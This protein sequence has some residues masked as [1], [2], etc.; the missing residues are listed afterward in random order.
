MSESAASKRVKKD[1]NAAEKARLTE[2][3]AKANRDRNREH[4]RNTRLRKK[5]RGLLHLPPTSL[6]FILPAFYPPSLARSLPPSLARFPPSLLA[7]PF[8]YTPSPLPS[9]ASHFT[10]NQCTAPLLPSSPPSS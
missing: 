4:A 2:C 3:K 5:V 10:E 8:I 1:L 9:F 6:P 7:F